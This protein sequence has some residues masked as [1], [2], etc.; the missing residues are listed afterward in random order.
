M[1]KKMAVVK[2]KKADD[3][4]KMEKKNLK[5][6]KQKEI[7]TRAATTAIATTSTTKQEKTVDCYIHTQPAALS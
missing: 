3:Q 6:E 2:T 7:S 4:N 5:K 1:I